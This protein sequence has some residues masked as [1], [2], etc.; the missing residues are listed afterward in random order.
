[1]LR[2]IWLTVDFA[3]VCTF[4]YFLASDPG[5]DSTAN[6]SYQTQSYAD[7]C[8][9]CKNG[10]W[11]GKHCPHC[12]VCI[13]GRVLHCNFLGKCIGDGKGTMYDMACVGLLLTKA[14]QCYL[15]T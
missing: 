5:V 9:K 6:L 2:G 8:S 3:I 11:L 4:G 14:V 15:L 12:D 7:Y 13:R 1:M 10:T